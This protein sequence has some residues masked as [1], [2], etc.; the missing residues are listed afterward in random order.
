MSK[1]TSIAGFIDEIRDN[2]SEQA[3]TSFKAALGTYKKVISFTVYC[4][5]T[6]N[7]LDEDLFFKIDAEKGHLYLH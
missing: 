3:Y 2:L 1:V 7:L 5:V 6:L 4:V